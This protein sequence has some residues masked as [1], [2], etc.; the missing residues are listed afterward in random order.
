MENTYYVP[1]Q[2]TLTST[3]IVH[4][5]TQAEAVKKTEEVIRKNAEHIA[6]NYDHIKIMES[7]IECAEDD[8]MLDAIIEDFDLETEVVD[9]PV[10]SYEG[11]VSEDKKYQTFTSEISIDGGGMPK[12][13]TTKEQ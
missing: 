12:C 3:L 11:E 1:V 5:K 8:K 7:E 10:V 4:A 9:R 2:Y 6:V 13:I